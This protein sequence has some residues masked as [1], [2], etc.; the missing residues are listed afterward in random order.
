MLLGKPRLVP[1]LP[2]AQTKNPAL[3]TASSENLAE[4]WEH[5]YGLPDFHRD[6]LGSKSSCQLD[7]VQPHPLFLT[8]MSYAYAFILYCI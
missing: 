4:A 7:M 1:R 6:C 8:D 2:H 3:C 5:G